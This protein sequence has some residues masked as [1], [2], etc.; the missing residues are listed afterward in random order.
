MQ[1]KEQKTSSLSKIERLNLANQYMILSKLDNGMAEEYAMRAQIFERGY[2]SLYH[3]ALDDIWDE[4]ADEMQQEVQNIL[5]LHRLMLNTARDLKDPD[6]SKRVKFYGFDGNNESGHLGYA[7]F[8]CEAP[9][10]N[11]YT[12]LQIRNSHHQTLDRYRLMLNAWRQMGEPSSLS[13]QQV[14]AILSAGTFGG[15]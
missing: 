14:E 6:L 5:W 4:A 2:T 9:N 8:Y 7:H 15:K 3:V 10:P 12:D 13:K 1:E 11:R